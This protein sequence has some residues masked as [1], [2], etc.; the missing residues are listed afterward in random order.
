MSSAAEVLV[1]I[2]S[3]ALSVFLVFATILA[4]YLIKLSAQIRKVTKSAEQTVDNIESVVSQATK[5]VT[6]M[7]FS[8]MINR[9]IK[10]FK[11][12]NSKGEQHDN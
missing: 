8:E 3:I 2:L 6:P 11:K 7:F 12:S 9:L 4:F 10:K 1:I 5:V